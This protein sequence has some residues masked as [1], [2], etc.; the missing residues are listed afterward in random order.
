M[1]WS[2]VLEYAHL[3]SSGIASD[4]DIQKI[5][6]AILCVE[7]TIKLLPDDGV[8]QLFASHAQRAFLAKLGQSVGRTATQL[9]LDIWDSKLELQNLLSED[10]GAEKAAKYWEENVEVVDE[11]YTTSLVDAVFTTMRRM[12]VVE[13]TQRVALR[14]D[15]AGISPFISCYKY[16]AVVKRA[17]N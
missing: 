5:R 16:E 8:K 3:I 11:K 15:A 9:M 2:P 1:I 6:R 12:F 17:P 13:E 14:A 4:E 7:I 10:V